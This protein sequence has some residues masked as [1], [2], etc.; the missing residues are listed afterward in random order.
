MEIRLETDHR[1]KAA[2]VLG[3]GGSRGAY[4]I[5]VWQALREM[6]VPIHMAAGTSVGSLNAAIIAQDAASDNSKLYEMAVD[7]WNR[8]DTQTAFSLSAIEL[9]EFLEKGGGSFDG[10]KK[11]LNENLDENAIRQSPVELGL[12]TVELPAMTPLHLWR[13]DIPIGKLSDYILASCACFPAVESYEIDDKKYV[14]GGYADNLPV[15]MAL[16]RGADRVIAVNLDAIGIVRKGSLKEAEADDRLTLIQSHWD[17]GNFMVF[18]QWNTNRIM[19]LGYLETL[20]AFGAYDGTYYSF[21]KGQLDRRTLKS[22]EAAARIFELSP[23][24]LYR[25]ELFALR[26]WEAIAKYERE[27]DSELQTAAAQL[28]EAFWDSVVR[29]AKQLNSRTITLLAAQGIKKEG[30]QKDLIL[31]R[32]IRSLFDD[33]VRAALWLVR[34]GLV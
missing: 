24:V 33:E 32:P 8:M 9:G 13:E 3:G 17:L 5:G 20:K 25:K 12:V 22:A 34:E 18:D 26:L 21:F 31:S 29:V 6:D 11:L 14:D 2:L 10:L 30:R 16:K 7:L 23:A 15:G 19:R 28:T 27:Q 1:A 4:E